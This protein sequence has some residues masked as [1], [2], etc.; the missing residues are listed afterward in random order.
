MKQEEAGGQEEEEEE[1]EEPGA[2]RS[3]KMTWNRVKLQTAHL[4]CFSRNVRSALQKP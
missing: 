2:G 4:E 3:T 1:G